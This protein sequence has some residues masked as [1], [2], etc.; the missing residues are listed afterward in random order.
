MLSRLAP[1]L[2]LTANF[3]SSQEQL[4]ANDILRQAETKAA[5][6]HQMVW[7]LFHASW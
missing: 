1:L 4:S 3:A 6:S 7:V 2:F 5:N